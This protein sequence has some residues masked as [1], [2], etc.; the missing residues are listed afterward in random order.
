MKILLADSFPESHAKMLEEN[1]HE[2][3]LDASLDE[4]SLEQAIADHEILIVRS[5]KVTA[6]AMD[7]G[8]ALKLIIRAGA[9]TNT[10][11]KSHA[12]DKGINVCNVPGAN[13]VAVA[14]LAMGL[15]LSIDR[16]IPQNGADLKNNVWNKK[17]YS[18]AQGLFG[19]N[20]GILGLGAIGLALAER[21]NA[22]GMKVYSVAKP[23]RSTEAEERIKYAGINQLS[24][25][26]ELL[27]KADIVSLH[28]PA[29]AETT[30]MVNAEF[31]GKMKAGAMLINTSRGE[32]VDE[33]ALIKAMNDRQI[34]AGLDVYNNEPGASDNTFESNVSAHQ[35]VCGTHHIG[36]STNQAQ[37][38]VSDGVLD[39]IH[40]YI[41]GNAI[42]CVN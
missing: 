17:K 7:A 11:D 19:Q 37:I 41:S 6:A 29:T 42:N 16:Q 18:K 36:A 9:G 23:G 24:S 8:T 15:I 39:V 31:L 5:T 34:R 40:S 1:G 27:A 32:L 33:E 26:D 30:G 28:L 4:N 12:A 3:T 22:F 14:E 10:I 21:A 20:I 35:N 38:A 13:A 2:L 25:Q